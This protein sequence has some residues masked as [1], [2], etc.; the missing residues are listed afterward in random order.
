M[1]NKHNDKCRHKVKKVYYKVKNWQKYNDALRKRGNITVW[2]TEE[3]IQ[4]WIPL[5]DSVKLTSAI[6]KKQPDVSIII[7][8][9]SDAII[10]QD[11]D[12]Q[13]EHTSVYSKRLDAYCI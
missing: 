6:W 5:C 10:S 12:T 2:F 11:A 8:P 4:A 7:P 13:E 1:P 9:P 3:A